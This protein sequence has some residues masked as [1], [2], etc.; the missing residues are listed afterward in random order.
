MAYD[1]FI[2][3]GSGIM[4]QILNQ[5]HIPL[6]HAPLSSATGTT[7]SA[8]LPFIVPVPNNID[9]YKL[10]PEDC[11]E[12]DELGELEDLLAK[13]LSIEQIIE[14]IN[15]KKNK[16]VDTSAFQFERNKRIQNWLNDLVPDKT[17]DTIH[18]TLAELVGGEDELKKAVELPS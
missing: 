11:F 1:N 9:D 13:G 12:G 7:N 4:N 16:D 17:M 6:E 8:N 14:M 18:D 5:G 10:T 3:Q 15:R 2:I